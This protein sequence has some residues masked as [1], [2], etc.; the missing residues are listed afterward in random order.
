MLYE[1]VKWGAVRMRDI[2]YTAHGI[3]SRPQS[4]VSRHIQSIPPS[5]ASQLY[6]EKHKRSRQLFNLHRKHQLH[7]AQ[8]ERDEE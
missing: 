2:R 1:C 3:A 5:P 7:L 4:I 8:G 6:V